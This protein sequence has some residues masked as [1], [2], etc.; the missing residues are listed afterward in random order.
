MKD[1]D[2]RLKPGRIRS[3]SGERSQPAIT[4]VLKAA[5]RAGGRISRVG[6]ITN[7]KRSTFGRGRVASV[8]ALH[9]LTNRSRGA[10]IKARVVRHHERS[11][12]AAHLSYV[13][14]DGVSRDHDEGRLFGATTDEV[15]R[16]Q[17]AA[18]CEHDRHHFRFIVSPED[19]H[20][21]ADVKSFT[22][23]LM[24]QMEKDLGT[25]LDWAATDHWDTQHPHVHIVV[26]GVAED[27]RDLVIARD[28][29][30]NGM[31]ARAQTLITQELGLRTDLEIRHALEQQ[32]EAERWTDLDRDLARSMKRDGFIDMVP[33]PDGQSLDLHALKMGRLRKLEHLGLADQLAPACWS[34]SDNA[35]A[36]LRDLGIRNDIIK[37][38]HRAMK[39]RQIERAIERF[40]LDARPGQSIMGRLVERGLHD[41][42]KG[43]A[44]AILDSMDGRTHHVIFPGIEATG[45]APSGA[46]VELRQFADRRG[47]ARIALAVRSDMN[48][49]Q[50]IRAPGA[51]WLDRQLVSQ[52]ASER[53]GIGFGAE[54]TQ[55]MEA[56]AGHLVEVGLARR[57]GQRIVFIRNLLESLQQREVTAHAEKLA[58]DLGLA[59]KPSRSGD[60]VAGTIRQR[61]S[62][63]SGRFAMI[64]GGLGFQLVPWSPSLDGNTGRHI[65]GV[66]R[67]D[68]H[69]DWSLDRGR[70]M[71]R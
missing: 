13:Q 4:Q 52:Q 10:I 40:V 23:S 12:L 6:K 11:S 53:V 22:R 65:S 30:S 45:D 42:L 19:V 54:V 68:G 50:Q 9:R 47:R 21:M 35:E 26:R 2:F 27:G 18:R 33:P 51:T 36:T 37:H 15:D 61:I 7:P 62:L 5:Q 29:I 55:A 56:R 41:E 59:H 14:R 67:G 34:L 32:V 63:S 44:Y 17:F 1:D 60:Y 28:Y 71:G 49:A 64:D 24:A 70:G 46:I 3:V 8:R 20:A 38:M 48:L 31:R 58:A 69:V 16:N 66:M 43:S 39:E 57:Q 25:K